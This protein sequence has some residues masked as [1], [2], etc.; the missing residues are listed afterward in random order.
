MTD[1]SRDT[2][3]VE[4]TRER[5]TACDVD[6]VVAGGGIAGVFAALGAARAGAETVLIDRFGSLGGNMGPGMISQGGIGSRPKPGTDDWPEQTQVFGGMKGFAREFLKRHVEIAGERA[7]NMV[8][9]NVASYLS[10]KMA[11]ENGVT[12]MLSAYASDPILKGDRVCGLFVENKS[13]RQA[14]LA[15]V[16]IDATGEADIA[17]RAGGPVIHPKPEYRDID[18]NHGPYGEGLYYELAGL[19]ADRCEALK[20]NVPEEDIQWVNQNVGAI[21]ERHSWLAPYIRQA[22]EH[23]EFKELFS[24][25]VFRREI[26]SIGIVPLLLRI[27]EKN[28]TASGATSNLRFDWADQAVI[29]KVEACSRISIYELSHFLK[30]YVPGFENSYLACIAPYFGERGGPCIEGEHVVTLDDFETGRR[31]PDV[32]YIYGHVSGGRDVKTGEGKWTD[33]PFRALLPKRLD[34]LIAVGRSAS[35]IPDTLIRGRTKAMHMGEAGGIAAALASKQG[36][37]PKQLDVKELQRKLLEIGF[38]LGN[39]ERLRELGIDS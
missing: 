16:I 24:E 25:G 30:K 1:E 8:D 18:P 26:P 34:G 7:G 2:Q 33:L 4:P 20:E 39:D 13:G 38:H 29:S 21:N 17:R 35:A 12:L 31:F 36:I 27:I 19:D 23:D 22:L 15:K 5:E 10:L 37:T 6:V 14:V 32:L 3:V 28:G 9:A 11:E